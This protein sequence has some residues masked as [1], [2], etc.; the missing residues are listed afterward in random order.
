LIVEYADDGIGFEKK[1]VNLESNGRGLQNIAARV[2]AVDGKC[3]FR[4]F[5]GKGFKVFIEI[6]II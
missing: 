6:P 3:V 4:T 5:P 1:R 2:K